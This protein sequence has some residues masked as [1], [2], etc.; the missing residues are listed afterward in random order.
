MLV[1][2]HAC[3]VLNA[4]KLNK[5]CSNDEWVAHAAIGIASLP[6]ASSHVLHLYPLCYDCTSS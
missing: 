2:I 3:L 1:A 4:G 6:N 5:S